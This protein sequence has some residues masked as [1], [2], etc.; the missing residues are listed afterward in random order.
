VY[1]LEFDDVVFTASGGTVGPF[2]YVVLYNSDASDILL[3]YY[4]YCA[5]VT[6]ADTETLLVEYTATG[7]AIEIG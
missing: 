4:D 6:L 7:V 2:Q 1:E 3:G 5:P